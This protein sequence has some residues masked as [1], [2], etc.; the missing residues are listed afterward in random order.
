LKGSPTQ[1]QKQK[2]TTTTIQRPFMPTIT[3]KTRNRTKEKTNGKLSINL[4]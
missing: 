2:K 4:N 1:T 3:Q